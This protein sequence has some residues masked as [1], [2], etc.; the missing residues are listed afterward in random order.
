MCVS[1]VLQGLVRMSAAAVFWSPSEAKTLC[2]TAGCI[3]AITTMCV[4]AVIAIFTCVFQYILSIIVDKLSTMPLTFCVRFQRRFPDFS[5]IT[6]NGRLTEFLDCVIIRLVCMFC[7]C[8]VSFPVLHC[9]FP[10][11][12]MFC[13]V[14][15]IWITAVLFLTWVRWWVTMGP[16]TW[17]TPPKPSAPSCWRTSGR[18]R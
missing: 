12:F 7:D 15:S 1:V 16:S 3:W 5:Y 9:D 6:Q 8:C 4:T 14:I 2:L 11:S 17:P 13:S 18:S 10:S